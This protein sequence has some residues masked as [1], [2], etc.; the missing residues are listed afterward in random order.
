M[1]C[2]VCGGPMVD[3]EVTYRLEI[4]G[5]L[6]VVEHVPAK[7]CVQC[8]ETLYS[9]KTVEYLQKTAWEQKSPSKVMETLVF[10]FSA[11]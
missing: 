11:R 7:V 4:E 3:Q 2:D 6:I 8:G 5:Q 9:A 1:P 10:D